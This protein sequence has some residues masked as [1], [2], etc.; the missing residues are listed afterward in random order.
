MSNVQFDTP[1]YGKL[2][3]NFHGLGKTKDFESEADFSYNGYFL[4]DADGDVTMTLSETGV[5]LKKKDGT[6]VTNPTNSFAKLKLY[7]TEGSYA[8]AEDNFEIDL[9]AIKMKRKLKTQF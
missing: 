3:I 7:E 1:C 4:G 9:S 6:P 5:E 2:R 8:Q